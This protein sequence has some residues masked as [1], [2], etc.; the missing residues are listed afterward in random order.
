VTVDAAQE[1]L[2]LMQQLISAVRRLNQSE[3]PDLLE[4]GRELQLRRRRGRR[5]IVDLVDR[6]TG[7]VLDEL[8]PDVV[9]RMMSELEKK[10]EGE[11]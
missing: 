2:G 3:L 5:P 1:G 4:Q 8:P 9:L 10:Q 11:L 6:E 7:E